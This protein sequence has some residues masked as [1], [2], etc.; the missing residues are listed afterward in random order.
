MQGLSSKSPRT[1]QDPR[2]SVVVPTHDRPASLRRCLAA[3]ADQ[4]I[5]DQLEVIVV[6]DG[7]AA[8]TAI[9]AA[10]RQ[11]PFARLI[12]QAQA[13]PASARNTGVRNA[14]AAVLCFTDDDC[15]PRP[16][17]AE[18]LAGA[19]EAGADAVAGR[20]LSATPGRA[21]TAAA[22]L[23]AEAPALVADSSDGALA[24]APTN[25]LACR[26][27]VLAAVP[28]DERYS[29]AAGEDRDWCARVRAAGYVLRAEVA[30]ALV[31]RPDETLRGFLRQQVR[32][33][34]GA[35]QFRA[36]GARGGLEPP[37]F[38]GRLVRRGFSRGPLVGLLVCAAQIATAIGFISE[39]VASR[40]TTAKIS[41]NPLR[42]SGD[43][44]KMMDDVKGQGSGGE[45]RP[46]SPQEHAVKRVV[47]HRD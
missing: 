34:R 2:V 15:E 4:T 46:A 26:A 9:A 5:S 30:A 12:R 47:E 14:R 43:A 21:I 19:I 28:F 35:Y 25:N 27:D 22:E 41:P 20:T 16:N 32:Y 17:W 18:D 33:G 44:D 36:W 1:A 6:D 37:A 39:S 29:T 8:A 24:F 23:V 31:H 3:L 40:P 7:S 45:G 42:N 11:H 13:G 10:T 38:Y